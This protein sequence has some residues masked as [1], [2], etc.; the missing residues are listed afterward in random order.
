ME[1]FRRFLWLAALL[2]LFVNVHAEGEERPYAYVLPTVP[3]ETGDKIE[4]RE[5]FWYT[6]PH[7]F[8]FKPYLD[9]WLENKPDDVE[10]IYMPAVY[11]NLKWVEFAK[12]FF[13]AQSLGVL[14][15]VHGPLFEAV[16]VQKRKLDKEEDFV[17]FVVEQGIDE[18]AFKNAYNSFETDRQV[19]NAL[20]LTSKYGVNAVPTLII[21]GKYRILSGK[22]NGHQNVIEVMEDLIEAERQARQKAAGE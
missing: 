2:G 17:K 1:I 8:G 7:C 20:I 21:N 22:I 13:A 9:K 12:T 10:V 3:T 15:K 6:C 14:D 19:R 16:H 18:S 11:T 4:I 5:I